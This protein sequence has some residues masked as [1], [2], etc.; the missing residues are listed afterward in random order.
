MGSE[1]VKNCPMCG[2]DEIRLNYPS[3]G[4][5]YY[6]QCVRCGLKIERILAHK[7]I[8]AWN[9]RANSE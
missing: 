5:E 3:T 8:A 6:M 7:A 4:G 9:R 1:R 2:C